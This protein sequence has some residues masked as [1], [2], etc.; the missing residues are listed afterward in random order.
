MVKVKAPNAI[1][2][3]ISLLG[4]SASLN[5]ILAR[6]YRINATTNKETPP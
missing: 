2:P 1:V 4:I 3:G 5:N 6:G